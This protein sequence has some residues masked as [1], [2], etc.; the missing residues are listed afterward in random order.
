MRQDE[1]DSQESTGTDWDEIRAAGDLSTE[2]G[3]EAFGR[4]LHRLRPMLLIH[5]TTKFGSQPAEAE[6]FLQSFLHEKVIVKGL[7]RQAD[8][9]RGR[10]Y[11]FLLNALDRFV[12]SQ[13]RR[14]HSRKRGC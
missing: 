12:L 4:A 10:F 1:R 3:R 9:E 13:L 14:R 5:L 2:Q 7:F 8:P 6:D 11:S